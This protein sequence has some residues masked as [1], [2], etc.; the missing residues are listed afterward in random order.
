MNGK[1]NIRKQLPRPLITRKG[2]RIRFVLETS[3]KNEENH[4]YDLFGQ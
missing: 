4:V 3:E 2:D 1:V